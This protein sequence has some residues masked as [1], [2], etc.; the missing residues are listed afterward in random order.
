MAV[1]ACTVKQAAPSLPNPRVVQ[2]DLTKALAQPKGAGEEPEPPAKPSKIVVIYFDDGSAV[3]KVT[4][5]LGRVVEEIREGDEILV[6]GH[7]HGRSDERSS[8]LSAQRAMAVASYLQKL[9]A[10][11]VYL[12]SSWGPL[13]NPYDPTKGVQVF[14]MKGGAAK[15]PGAQRFEAPAEEP[16]ADDPR[17]KI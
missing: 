2:R 12:M 11:K 13:M 15:R 10:R 7:S 16:K 4:G 8:S 6:V 9:G 1:S 17:K 14:V 5:A 3:L